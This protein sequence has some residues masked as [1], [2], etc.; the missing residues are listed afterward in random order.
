VYLAG[1][2]TGTY[3]PE[4]LGRK[5]TLLSKLGGVPAARPIAQEYLRRFPGGTYAG[6]ARAF[7]PPP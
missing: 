5:M 2:P 1:E 3:A 6:P 7:A 4:A